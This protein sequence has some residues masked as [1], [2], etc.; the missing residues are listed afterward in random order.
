MWSKCGDDTISLGRELP[1]LKSL[2]RAKD[3]PNQYNDHVSVMK[4][5]LQVKPQ[6]WKDRERW[7][8]SSLF[9]QDT[10]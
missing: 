4:A 9:D 7:A 8:P 3:I 6:V 10:L 2:S 5:N 1:R